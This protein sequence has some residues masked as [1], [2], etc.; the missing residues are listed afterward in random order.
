MAN[1]ALEVLRRELDFLRG[2]FLVLMITWVMFRFAFRMVI[3]YEP[4]FIS[5]LGADETTLG[6]MNSIYAAVLCLSL[7]PGSYVADRW[8]RR[9]IIVVMTYALGLSYLFYV[10]APSWQLVLVGMVMAA[11]CRVYSPALS[12]ITAD[13]L[14]PER[15][16]M[17]YSMMRVLPDAVAVASPMITVFLIQ[18]YGFLE[19]LRLAYMVVVLSTLAAATLRLFFLKE[20]LRPTGS[21]MDGG[22]LAKVYARAVRDIA[23]TVKEAPRPLKALIFGPLLVVPLAQGLWLF[24]PLFVV[25][26]S[27]VSKEEWGL[28]NTVCTAV[29]LTTGIILGKLADRL[30]RKG[31]LV[32]AYALRAILVAALALASGFTQVLTV[33]VL[34]ELVY[35]LGFPATSAL[36]ADLTPREMRGRILG[37]RTLLMNLMSIPAPLVVGILYQHVDPRIPFFTTSA[38]S[39][40]AAVV[41]ALLVEEP[42]EKAI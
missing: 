1:R 37:A 5:E 23:Y 40:L 4:L 33:M 16:G 17:G 31:L 41:L 12:A 28:V 2:N 42:E 19:A 18:R 38:L 11:L 30:S 35:N 26:Y 3:P 13:S 25:N 32:S 20:T 22:G 29:G 34:F 7:I 27:G 14:P 21:G 15:R 39:I 24:V 10:L 6:L 8:G 36:L 9:R